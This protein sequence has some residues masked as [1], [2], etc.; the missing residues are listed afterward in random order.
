MLTFE[1]IRG[2]TEPQL[3]GCTR[4]VYIHVHINKVRS[5]RELAC[6]RVLKAL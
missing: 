5:D 1:E 4:S 2:A 6:F 3:Q